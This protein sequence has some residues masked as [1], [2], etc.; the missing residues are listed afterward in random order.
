MLYLC[1]PFSKLEPIDGDDRTVVR[2][3]LLTLFISCILTA[4]IGG[5]VFAQTPINIEWEIE[6]APETGWTIGDP[7]NVKLVAT[8]SSDLKVSLPQLPAEW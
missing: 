3:L 5:H 4:I 2:K 6:D 7:I 8:S 1:S